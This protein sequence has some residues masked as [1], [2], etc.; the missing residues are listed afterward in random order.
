MAPV[1]MRA[2]LAALVE[3]GALP[4][5][6]RSEIADS[7]RRSV[8]AGLRPHQF[9]VPFEPDIDGD[10]VLVRAAQPVLNDLTEDLSESGVGVVLTDGRGHVIARDVGQRGLRR[11]FDAIQLAPGSLY[12]E[13]LIGTNA[14]GTALAQRSASMVMGAEHF[15]EALTHMACA[16]AP[17]MDPRSGHTI[18]L[19]DLTCEAKDASPLILSIARHAAR[20]I[21]QRLI[22]EQVVKDRVLLQQFL[23]RRRGAKGA[24][25]FVNERRMIT[26]AAAERLVSTDDASVL[27]EVAARLLVHHDGPVDVVLGGGIFTVTDCQP[28]MD[29]VSLL[30]ALLSLRPLSCERGGKVAGLTPTEQ[31]VAVLTAEGLTNRQIGERLYMSRY[32]V[33]THLRSI[34]AKLGV[35]SRVE[36]TRALLGSPCGP[37]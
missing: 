1:R 35:A 23:R 3:D 21:E 13:D 26:N 18:G 5:P 16:A 20:D 6:I 37:E 15:V 11:R 8:G 19:L 30:G 12:G 2:A 31:S 27:W 17:V 9:E 25:L 29:G 33:D 24:L 14:I 4:A 32:T 22:E 34:F 7:W 36:L 28:V 10:T